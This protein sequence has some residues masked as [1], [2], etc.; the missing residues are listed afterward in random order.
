MEDVTGLDGDLDVYI[1]CV[2]MIPKICHL[3]DSFYQNA[4]EGTQSPPND[5]FE[6]IL[7]LSENDHEA[8]YQSQGLV[9]TLGL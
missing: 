7:D 3:W 1:H 8:Y 6:Y 4:P 5:Q 2:P 9:W